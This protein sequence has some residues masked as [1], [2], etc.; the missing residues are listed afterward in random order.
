ML[1]E[2]DRIFRL[3]EAAEFLGLG[4]ST[5]RA[6]SNPK[7]PLYDPSFPRQV[8]LGKRARGYWGSKL[9]AWANKRGGRAHG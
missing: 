1:D 9:R 3:T 8:L 5:V 6:K 2:Q 4:I 7:S